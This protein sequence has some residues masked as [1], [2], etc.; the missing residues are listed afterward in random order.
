LILKTVPL[1]PLEEKLRTIYE[2]N[3]EG[4]EIPK[5]K[6]FDMK[7]FASKTGSS[8]EVTRPKVS[9]LTLPSDS[10][11]DGHPVSRRGSILHPQP[12]AN[13]HVSSDHA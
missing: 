5:G 1:L 11:S 12:P 6:R 13:S 7:M 9:Q 8:F 10:R 3:D 4:A 2:E